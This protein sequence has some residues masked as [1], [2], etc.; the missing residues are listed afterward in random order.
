[1]DCNLKEL[2][3][4]K[5][6]VLCIVDKSLISFFSWEVFLNILFQELKQQFHFRKR[7]N[8]SSLSMFP[9]ALGISTSVEE[10]SYSDHFLCRSITDINRT[11]D[12]KGVKH[13]RDPSKMEGLRKFVVILFAVQS[14][15]SPIVLHLSDRFSS[16]FFFGPFYSTLYILQQEYSPIKIA[17]IFIRKP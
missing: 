15:C 4:F 17:S 3:F 12:K 16:F 8:W 1:M 9:Y 11:F 6:Y 5:F 10:T 7:R 14:C 13:K 2:A